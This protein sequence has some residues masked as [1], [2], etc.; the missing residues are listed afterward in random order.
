MDAS[1]AMPTPT[2]YVMTTL[3]KGDQAP[4]FALLDQHG[5]MV[6]LEDYRGR[7]LL[8][9]FYPEADTPGC[10]TQSCDLRDH[11]QDLAGIGLDVVGISPDAPPKQLAFDEKYGLGFPLLADDDHAVAEAWSAW[12]E[13][14]RG[15]HT[16]MGILR[17]SFLVDEEGRIEQAWSP[18]KPEDTVPNAL[19]AAAA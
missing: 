10:T 13:R 17:S 15:G 19:A 1:F 6:R 7:K 2:V 5:D 18:V 12:T 16:F 11:R 4:G 9:Y 8:V 3:Q 14:H